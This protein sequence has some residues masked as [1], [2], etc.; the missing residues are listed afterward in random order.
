MIRQMHLEDVPEIQKLIEQFGVPCT[1]NEV[2]DRFTEVSRLSTHAL[3]VA[4]TD[5]G[6]P[7]GLVQVNAEQATLLF[8]L[9]S[10]I[11]LLVVDANYRSNGI[12]KALV[13][14]AEEWAKSKGLP[15][16]RIRSN[17][18]REDAHRFYKRE[19]YELQK[20]WH[21]FTKSIKQD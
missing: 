20:S 13:A 14:K 8:G 3:F 17:I 11:T 16:M 12:G 5:T 7:V 15:L 2:H 1:E 18:H 21:L 19:G 10:E 4:T 9:R 6:K